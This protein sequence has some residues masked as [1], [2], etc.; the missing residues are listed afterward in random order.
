[1]YCVPQESHFIGGTVEDN[2]RY[3]WLH[4]SEAELEQILV[5][6]CMEEILDTPR[7]LNMPLQEG[8]SN[9]SGGQKQRLA[10][11][12]MILRKPPIVLLDEATSALDSITESRILDTISDRLPHSTIV[13]IT[14]RIHTASKADKIFVLED[15][16]LIGKGSYDQLLKSCPVFSDMV[17]RGVNE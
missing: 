5:D 1:M 10:I 13:F 7:K 15:G 12:R 14:H 8:G 17:S 11:G 6:V 4:S 2:L 9:L 3:G 16:Y